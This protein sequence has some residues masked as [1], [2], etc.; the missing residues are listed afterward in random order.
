MFVPSF[1]SFIFFFYVSAK[2]DLARVLGH[3][4]VIPFEHFIRRIFIYAFFF[5]IFSFF[6]L[7]IEEPFFIIS[8]CR[9]FKREFS[10]CVAERRVMYFFS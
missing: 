5:V 6:Y 4:A 2:C 3:L 1:V 10:S 7:D 8:R 9:A